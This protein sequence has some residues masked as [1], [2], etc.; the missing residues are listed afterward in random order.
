MGIQE[1]NYKILNKWAHICFLFLIADQIYLG[2]VGF[3][4]DNMSYELE[5][6]EQVS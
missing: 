6:S 1:K 2:H 5:I 4:N 3:L